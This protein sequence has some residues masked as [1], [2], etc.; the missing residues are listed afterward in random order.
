MAASVLGY[1]TAGLL[2]LAGLLLL[3]G[4]TVVNDISDS[5]DGNDHG[6][7]AEF[8]FD[9]VG[10]LVAAGLLIAGGSMLTTGNWRGRIWI[11]F[12]TA[13]VA[14]FSIYWIIRTRWSGV[15]VWGV[16][17]TAMPVIAVC[18]AFSRAVTDWLAR[19]PQR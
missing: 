16:I 1:I 15:V 14:A 13:I 12:G 7:T 6:L 2:I 8:I 5:L 11:A 4:A 3:I 17:F 18:L 19:Q 10:N 9:G